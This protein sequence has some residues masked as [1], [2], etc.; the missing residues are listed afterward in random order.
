M[1]TELTGKL[2]SHCCPCAGCWQ[3]WSAQLL[4]HSLETAALFITAASLW[5]QPSLDDEQAQV[6]MKAVSTTLGCR[7][8][9]NYMEAYITAS[10]LARLYMRSQSG[11]PLVSLSWVTGKQ[12]LAWR[13]SNAF[14]I[15]IITPMHAQQDI[16]MDDRW[17]GP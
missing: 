16:T 2:P 8:T 5:L 7:P 4:F 15:V 14:D 9:G 17:Q 1:G 13:Q 10:I 6:A 3:N 11:W 12:I